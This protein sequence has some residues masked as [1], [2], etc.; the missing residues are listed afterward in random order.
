MG[1]RRKGVDMC[2]GDFVYSKRT[3]QCIVLTG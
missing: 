2:R 1:M 3:V